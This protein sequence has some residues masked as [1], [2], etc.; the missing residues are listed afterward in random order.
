MTRTEQVRTAPPRNAPANSR[1]TRRPSLSNGEFLEKALEVFYERGFEGAS[2]DAITAAAGIAKR[3]IYAR[4]GDKENL[5]KA[6]IEWG[7]D[8]WNLPVEKLRKAESDNL[9]DSLF[10]IG[11]L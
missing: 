8:D 3:T 4:Y 9:E 5:F 7:I 1:R 2:I 10:A 11:Q 6:A